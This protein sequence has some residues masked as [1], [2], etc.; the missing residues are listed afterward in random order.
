MAHGAPSL[1]SDE[2]EAMT[3]EMRELV[4]IGTEKDEIPDFFFFF[5]SRAR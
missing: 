1:C 3:E 5:S 2:N 4:F